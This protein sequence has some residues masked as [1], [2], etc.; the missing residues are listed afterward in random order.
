MAVVLFNA[1]LGLVVVG[2]C[3]YLVVGQVEHGRDDDDDAA[4][5]AGRIH[6]DSV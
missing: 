4:G 3:A 5:D 6:H 1:I 2:L